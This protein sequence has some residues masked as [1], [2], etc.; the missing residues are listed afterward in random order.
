M[1]VITLETLRT[2]NNFE[3][4]WKMIEEN[5]I[6]P[7]N[8]L[9]LDSESNLGGMTIVPQLVIFMRKL[10]IYLDLYTSALDLIGGI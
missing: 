4:F 8:L 5:F 10:K 7:Q 6:M 3:L 9:F 2:Y 1:T